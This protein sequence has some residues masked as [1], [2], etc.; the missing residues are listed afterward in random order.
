MRF[1]ITRLPHCPRRQKSST[2]AR[3]A[4]LLPAHPQQEP[5]LMAGETR[6][7]CLPSL[8][9]TAAQKVRAA[10]DGWNSRNAQKVALAYTEDSVWRNR[11]EFLRGRD[12]IEAFLTRKWVKE[13]DYRPHQG[14]V[15]VRR[16]SHR[17]ALRLRMARRF[18]QLVPLVRQRELGVR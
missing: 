17:R 6:P 1:E 4:L 18:E 14:T 2:D 3:V 10:E 16:Q 13:L 8:Q 5:V 11:S 12:A 7:L 15:D 9:E